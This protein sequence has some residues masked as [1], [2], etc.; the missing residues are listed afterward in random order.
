MPARCLASAVG[1]ISSMSLGP[2]NRLMMQYLYAT[3]N[4]KFS[5]CQ[6]LEIPT[7]ALVEIEFWLGRLEEFNGQD[8]WP[9]PLAVKVVY[10]YASASGYGGYTIEHGNIVAN[11]QWS[12]SEAA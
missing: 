6:R 9:K 3:L 8:I 5:W 4:K 12:S 10:S 7:E 2:V 1:N 11:G